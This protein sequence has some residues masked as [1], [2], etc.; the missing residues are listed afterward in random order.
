MS[1]FDIF[2]TVDQPDL[3]AARAQMALSLAWHIV[4][5]CFGVGL[6]L[7]ILV[8]E[9]RGHRGGGPVYDELAHRWAKVL[10]SCSRSGPCRARS[11]RSRLGSCGRA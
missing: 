2:V 4:I 5:A 7:L 8:V 6:P 1:L 3:W 10:A 11:S 9:F